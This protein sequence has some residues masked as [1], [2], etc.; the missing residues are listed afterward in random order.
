[1]KSAHCL[2]MH[3][4]HWA[5]GIKI[6]GRCTIL[7][8]VV[9]PAKLIVLRKLWWGIEMVKLKQDSS[10][11]LDSGTGSVCSHHFTS[12]SLQ[13]VC[14]MIIVLSNQIGGTPIS[15]FSLTCSRW[16]TCNRCVEVRFCCS[17]SCWRGFW[18][19]HLVSV[20]CSLVGVIMMA[21]AL[22]H[23]W[24]HLQQNRSIFGH[25]FSLPFPT[26]ETLTVLLLLISIS[27]FCKCSLLPLLLFFLFS[28]AFYMVLAFQINS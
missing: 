22:L 12:T 25:I 7:F 1:M 5:I 26:I 10:T 6:Y 20:H 24:S 19:F 27:S 16:Q 3:N 8:V 18:F 14:A 13:S 2:I 23:L 15:S 9:Q 4:R 28:V 17:L 11:C 21:T